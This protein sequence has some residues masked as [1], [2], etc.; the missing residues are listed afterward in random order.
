M[1]SF[2]IGSAQILFM[3]NSSLTIL[4]HFVCA[5]V[6]ACVAMCIKHTTFL[7]VLE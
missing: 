2:V 4:S 7:G 5:F 1:M 3:A 6:C